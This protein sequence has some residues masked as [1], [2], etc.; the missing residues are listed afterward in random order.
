MLKKLRDS[1][2]RRSE[3][4]PF[5]S[6][7]QSHLF[8][9]AFYE[10]YNMVHM[11]I[12]NNHFLQTIDIGKNWFTVKLVKIYSVTYWKFNG[13][14][15]K[16]FFSH[17][18]H[19]EKTLAISKFAPN[20]RCHT[21]NQGVSMCEA[22][23]GGRYPCVRKNHERAQARTRYC[24]SL[25]IENRAHTD[26]VGFCLCVLTIVATMHFLART[27]QRSATVKARTQRRSGNKKKICY[28][29][30]VKWITGLRTKDCCDIVTTLY[31]L[32]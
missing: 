27:P 1:N 25:L 16:M 10:L 5:A 7:A 12:L 29:K 23:S 11:K 15:K 28:N 30:K 18:I 19:T 14:I 3:L 24:S 31:A 21:D 6:S 17:Q 26:V 9:N 8:A 4:Q 20:T 32:L 22:V 13:K 2:A